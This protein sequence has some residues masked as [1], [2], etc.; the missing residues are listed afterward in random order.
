[1]SS[2][3]SPLRRCPPPP[4]ASCRENVLFAAA[5]SLPRLNAGSAQIPHPAQRPRSPRCRTK[6]LCS[7]GQRSPA[8]R[9]RPQA[10]WRSAGGER[11]KPSRLQE[12]SPALPGARTELP[13]NRLRYAPALLFELR[14]NKARDRS[15]E[16]G[17]ASL[18]CH[19][20]SC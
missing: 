11:A 12:G 2:K 9:S 8:P 4:A 18:L 10:R 19:R 17:I 1:M 13:G 5:L 3:H 14:G 15:I 20:Y 16:P 7:A 6:P